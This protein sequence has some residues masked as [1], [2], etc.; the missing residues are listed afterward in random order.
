MDQVNRKF[1]SDVSQESGNKD[2]TTGRGQLALLR[3]TGDM[4]HLTCRTREA[5]VALER[6]LINGRKRAVRKAQNLVPAF[7]DVQKVT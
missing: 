5:S 4:W 7:P 1:Q 2:K 3:V 6:K